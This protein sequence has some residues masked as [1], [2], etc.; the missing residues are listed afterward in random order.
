MENLINKYRPLTFSQLIGQEVMVRVITNSI[1]LNRVANAFLLTGPHGTGK[2]STAR[3]IA[4]SLNCNKEMPIKPCAKC[5]NCQDIAKSI[6]MD[7]TEMDAASNTGVD[8]IRSILE[9]SRYLPVQASYKI[10]IIDEVHMLS[11]NAFNALL[12]T[13]EEPKPH[14]KFILATTEFNKVPATIV[15]RCQRFHL[16]RV[17]VDQLTQYLQQIAQRES[18]NIT[19]EA[20]T[21]IA[22]AANGSARDALSILD[23]AIGYNPQDISVQDVRSILGLSNEQQILELVQCAI[24]SKAKSLIMLFHNLYSLGGDPILILQ[25]VLDL[26]HILSR[27]KILRD[28]SEKK[29]LQEMA[30]ECSIEKLNRLWQV[31]FVGIQDVKIA[32][33]TYIASEMILLR[34]CYLSSLP[35]P[36]EII[37]NNGLITSDIKQEFTPSKILHLFKCNNEPILYNYL[38]NN[39]QITCVNS[40]TITLSVISHIGSFH[41]FKNRFIECLNKWTNQNWKLEIIDKSREYPVIN[42]VMQEFS[43]AKI[44]NIKKV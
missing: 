6:H 31:I 16:N 19:Q 14:V 28:D 37:K 32:P 10:Y 41:E 24:N 26:L 44:T 29:E 5:S 15:S 25:E 1:Q 38:N 12:K 13:L 2:T 40:D 3:I 7:V 17:A 20:A 30:D 43:G 34:V 35:S 33:N 42:K 4:K 36:G 9:D 11:I 21:L 27:I 8:D 22:N 23:Q 39:I 18:I